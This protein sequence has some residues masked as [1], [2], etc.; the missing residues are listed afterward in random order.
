SFFRTAISARRHSRALSLGDVVT[1][2][3]DDRG[4][5]GF[6]R[7]HAS[8]RVLAL[9]NNGDT[10]LEASIP[11]AGGISDVEVPDLLSRLPAARIINGALYATIPSLGAGWF[12]L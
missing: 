3:I 9:F 6:L 10:P 11:L 2:W 4:G 7:T 12:R 5:Y 8:E 1:V